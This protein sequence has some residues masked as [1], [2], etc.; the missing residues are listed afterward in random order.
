MVPS[1]ETAET[2]AEWRAAQSFGVKGCLGVW[3]A[4]VAR[5]RPRLTRGE[6]SGWRRM[7]LT[8]SISKVSGPGSKREKN[9]PQK[10]LGRGDDEANKAAAHEE[11]DEETD[12]A[13]RVVDAQGLVGKQ[14][15][16][17]VGAVEWRQREHV[18]GGEDEVEKHRDIAEADQGNEERPGNGEDAEVA[19]VGQLM[20][21]GSAGG[22]GVREDE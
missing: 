12:H 17:D 16:E 13:Q 14:V 5:T 4:G 11:D 21:D 2:P 9:S 20:D 15:A 10:E 19:G 8:P 6:S 18:E 1:G 22:A 3:A 7:N